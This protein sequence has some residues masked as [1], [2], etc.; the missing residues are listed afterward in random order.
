MK[1]SADPIP[2][3]EVKRLELD[4]LLDV[5]AFC[6]SHGIR[7]SLCAGTLLGAVRHR[8]F[9][10]WDDD[11]DIMLPRPDFER[12]VAEYVSDKPYKVVTN[13]TDPDYPF[14]YA[15]V[16]DTRTLKIEEKLRPR[17]T[18]TLGVNVDVFPLDCVPGDLESATELYRNIQRRWRRLS[19]ATCRF[20][21]GKSF[22]STFYRNIAIAVYRLLE[23]LGFDSV[24]R[25]VRSS[26]AIATSCNPGPSGRT[27]VTSIWHYGVRESH[28]SEVYEGW[29]DYPFEGH[30][31]KGITRAA[32][33]LTGMYGP[34]Y[35]DLPPVEKRN[36]H[37]T[38]SCYWKI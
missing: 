35:M 36:T 7:Y 28:P 8:G 13:D 31:F 24:R 2:L 14:P 21:R 11:I 6:E 38:S 3:D 18:R 4:I 10:P 1:P 32:D 5:A 29:S 23:V 37:H 12:F 22:V 15:A 20:G 17:C 19:S 26:K 34:D 33:Y 27:G 16:N 25:A 9:I 30:A